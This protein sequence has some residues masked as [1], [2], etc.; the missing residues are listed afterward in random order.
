[1][2]I[3]IGL[4]S[5]VP[6]ASAADVLA[7]A[8]IADTAQFSTLGTLD[9]VV[10]DNYDPITVLAAAAAVTEHIGLTTSILI[11][12]Y[13]GN[14]AVLAKQLASVDRISGGRLT[15]G[16]AVG[17]R[18]DDFDVT[19]SDYE[20]RGR[21]M[22]ALLS[23][24]RSVW[25]SDGTGTDA[26]GPRPSQP[27][28]PPL[29]IGGAGKPTLRRVV[30]YGSG[31]IAGGGDAD[32][33]AQQLRPVQT[34]WEA[35]GRARSPRTAALAYFALGTDAD[36]AATQ[37]LGNYYGF[38]GDYAKHTIAGA[39]T[40]PAKIRDA[41]TAYSDSGCDELIMFPCASDPDLLHRLIDVLSSR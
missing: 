13:R 1:M 17:A 36:A 39:L 26:V 34:A 40:S 8:R 5:T 18:R 20:G 32:T 22:D 35:A 21:I 2:R 28:G 30:E 25:S 23:G 16:I 4:P 33:F 19:G 3:G 38:A 15:V 6:A 12:P 31:W 29:L 7:W 14:G 41:V 27:G 24:M 10:F 9:R 11:G 37:Y